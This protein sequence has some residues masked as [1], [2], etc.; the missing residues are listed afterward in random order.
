MNSVSIVKI[1]VGE[2]TMDVYLGTPAR[3]APNPAIV[4]MYHRG[5]IDNFTEG[6]V[7]RLAARG[8]L[9]AVPD[10]YHRCPGTIPIAERKAL[11]RDSDIVADVKATVHELRSRSGVLHDRIAVM[12]HCMGGRMALL[13]AGSLPGFCGVVVYYGGSVERSWGG[14]GPTPFD[15][16][17]NIRCPV[18]GFFGDKDTHP[19]PEDVNR[20]D[21]E[22]SAHGVDHDFHRYP[23]VGHGFQ[24]PAHDTAAERFAAEDAWGKTFTF[25]RK[26]APA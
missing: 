25:L 5:G 13:A 15:G 21:A 16:L 20:I 1:R 7:E 8:Y 9:V 18:I 2:S 4:L 3:E 12:G 6:V 14:D 24:N 10:I 22:L 26:V 17:R 19:S 23:A 11:L